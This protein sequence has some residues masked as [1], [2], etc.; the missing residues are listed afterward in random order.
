MVRGTEEG[1][2][3]LVTGWVEAATVPAAAVAAGLGGAA[4]AGP[5]AAVAAGLREVV[6]AGLGEAVAARL[7][8]AA[9][10]GLVTGQVL[11]V[12]GERWWTAFP[13]SWIG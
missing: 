10:A 12:L 3:G 2:G 5:V 8:E 6:P 4:A 11:P 1:A 13:R 7:G 9:A